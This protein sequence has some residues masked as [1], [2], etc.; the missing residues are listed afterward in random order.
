MK[1]NNKLITKNNNQDVM[2]IKTQIVVRKCQR[3]KTSITLFGIYYC[4]EMVR[5]EINSHMLEI[6]S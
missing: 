4:V 3:S 2:V 1:L 6:R 5:I